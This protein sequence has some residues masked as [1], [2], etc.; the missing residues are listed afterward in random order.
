MLKIICVLLCVD[1]SIS[2][3]F[4]DER[5]SGTGVCPG[6]TVYVTCKAFELTSELLR[7]IIPPDSV[8]PTIYYFGDSDRVLLERNISLVSNS[9]QGSFRNLTYEITV[10][11]TGSM[12]NRGPVVCFDINIKSMSN[13]KVKG[14]LL[15]L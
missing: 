15:L 7:V 2:V 5:C 6:D 13:C 1:P 14:E 11:L 4:S 8:Y 3:T 10:S 9:V 12:L